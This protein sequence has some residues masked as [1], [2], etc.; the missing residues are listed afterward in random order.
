MMIGEAHAFGSPSGVPARRF[1]GV[2]GSHGVGVGGG[3]GGGGVGVGAAC[4]SG[5]AGQ[6]LLIE[7]GPE[8]QNW[9][10]LVLML[11]PPAVTFKV[12]KQVPI[13]AKQ[14]AAPPAIV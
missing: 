4:G 7:T 9:W 12:T 13:T 11:A 8:F 14:L 3:G 10:P 2:P 5:S 1:S 6:L